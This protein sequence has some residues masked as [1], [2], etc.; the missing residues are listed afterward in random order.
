MNEPVNLPCFSWCSLCACFAV[1]P[2]SLQVP[3]PALSFVKRLVSILCDKGSACRRGYVHHVPA[4]DTGA[5]ERVTDRSYMQ[6]LGAR[7]RS[8]GEGALY[9]ERPLH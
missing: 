3:L 4:E 9:T 6:V 7:P 8:S 2:P 1:L 5:L